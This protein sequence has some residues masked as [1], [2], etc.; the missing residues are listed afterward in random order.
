[1]ETRL[2]SQSGLFARPPSDHTLEHWQRAETAPTPED[3]QTITN[4]MA[5]GG[6]SEIKAYFVG[7]IQVALNPLAK[8]VLEA[9]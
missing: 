5:K 8:I 2:A 3:E 1:L 6:T 9:R 4:A 7:L